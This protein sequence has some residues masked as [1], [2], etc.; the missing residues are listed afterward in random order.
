MNHKIL[1]CE[2]GPF[3]HI[4]SSPLNMFNTQ[5]A[6]K[7]VKPP[8]QELYLTLYWKSACAATVLPLMVPGSTSALLLL[9]LLWSL[10]S[11]MTSCWNLGGPGCVLH[12]NLS[13]KQILQHSDYTQSL[14]LQL[15][16]L[17]I[18]KTIDA[19]SRSTMHA[20]LDSFRMLKEI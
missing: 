8:T 6:V 18:I 16:S 15:T 10:T 2:I 4:Y 14:C 3:W 13:A 12:T 7:H 20:F 5:R 17:Q 11:T 1:L 9:L 19:F